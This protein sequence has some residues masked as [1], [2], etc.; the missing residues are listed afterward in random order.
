MLF[1]FTASVSPH[2]DRSSNSLRYQNLMEKGSTKGSSV[3]ELGQVSGTF[4]PCVMVWASSAGGEPGVPRTPLHE[5][6]CYFC[7]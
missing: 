1:S 5:A 6:R 3:G 4:S 7:I 2:R